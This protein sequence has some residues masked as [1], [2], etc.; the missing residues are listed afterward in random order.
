MP[1][2]K[3]KTLEEKLADVRANIEK[4]N[5][6]LEALKAAEQN[7]LDQIRQRDIKALENLMEEK[8]ITV[9]ELKELIE[10]K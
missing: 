2:G 6:A 5:A 4:E 1:R 3:V 9:Q 10:K 8:G 7:L